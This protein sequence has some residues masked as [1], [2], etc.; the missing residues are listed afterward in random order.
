[1]SPDEVVEVPHHTTVG[2]PLEVVFPEA[3]IGMT[4]DHK[5]LT[6]LRLGTPKYPMSVPPQGR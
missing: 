5:H 3:R 1:M 4:R 6:A 2:M